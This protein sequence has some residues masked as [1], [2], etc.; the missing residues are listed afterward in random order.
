MS[1]L[2]ATV[3]DRSVWDVWLSAYH[4]PV[5]TVADEVGTFKAL[6]GRSLT[7]E[8]LAAEIGADARALTIHLAVLAGLG[9]VERREGRWSATAEARRWLHPEAEAYFG[10]L[11]AGPRASNPI[12]GHLLETLRTGDKASGHGSAA[13][14]W[15][16]GEMSDELAERVTA[17]ME[18]HSRAPARAVA[19]Q[20]RFADV[21]SFMDVGGGSGIFS[22]E[23]AKAW[24]HLQ[25]TVMDIAAVCRQAA[26]Y[27][28]A[29]GMSER[30]AT[31]A[32]NMFTEEWP[33][34]HD[35]HFFSNI[36]HDWSDKTCRLLAEKSF[37]AL[38]SGGT[39]LLHEM[40]MDDDLCGPLT[41]AS[42]SI[43]ML[44]GTRG[45][46][47]TLGELKDFLEGAGFVDVRSELTGGGYYSLV[48]ATKP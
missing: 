3:N 18:A 38:P 33:R 34:G 9:F 22:I 12:H 31:A 16:R 26:K 6:S 35:A 23:L 36:F 14:E 40:L 47:Y 46:Q 37:A 44:L 39:I 1:A 32:V 11:L 20:P 42:F 45:R 27:A 29:A 19:M 24:P 2:P 13:V 28:E 21:R 25:T 4:M 8:E 5:V 30:V 10:G 15:E 7:S 17:L 43:L 48:S 41:T